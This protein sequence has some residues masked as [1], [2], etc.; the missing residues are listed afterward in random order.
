MEAKKEPRNIFDILLL[1]A[2]LVLVIN[3]LAV[4]LVPILEEKATQAG[5]PPPP[6]AFRDMLREQGMYWLLVEL[7]ILIVCGLGSMILDHLRRLKSEQTSAT[8]STSD[9]ANNPTQ[10]NG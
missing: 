6:S 10:P 1:L 4:A 7:A 8:I 3:A 5:N 2:G 9:E